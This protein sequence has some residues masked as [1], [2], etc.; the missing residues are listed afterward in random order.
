VVELSHGIVQNGTT[1][2][3]FMTK[4]ST[5]NANPKGRFYDV[6]ISSTSNF[7]V[8][9]CQGN[10]GCLAA[11]QVFQVSCCWGMCSV[12]AQGTKK[13]TMTLVRPASQLLQVM[14]NEYEIIIPD[15][16]GTG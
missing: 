11:A 15:H 3:S 13:I 14:N 16:R 6:A 7:R 10:C 12:H 1:I 5:N 9:T 8:C 2:T 4:L